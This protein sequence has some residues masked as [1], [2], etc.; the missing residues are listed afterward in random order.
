MR[1]YDMSRMMK[2]IRMV[3]FSFVVCHLSLSLCSCTEDDNTVEEFPN[4]RVNNETY[5]QNL[6]ESTKS[7]IAAGDDS[8]KLIPKYSYVSTE[9]LQPTDYVIAHVKEVGEG[10]ASPIYTDT[11]R[12]HYR[13][14]LLPSTSYSAGYQFDSSYSGDLNPATATPGKFA[15]SSV[16]PG[17]ISALQKMHV[18]DRWELY[19]PYQL[20]YGNTESSVIPAYSTLIFDM[21]LVKIWHAGENDPGW[22]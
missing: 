18:G 17:W 21:M 7:K 14:R 20:G 1:R 16:V 3:G 22:K 15:V 2:W 4:W 11:V 13:G 19:I 9:G 12:V 8:W 10:T 5:W 6:Y